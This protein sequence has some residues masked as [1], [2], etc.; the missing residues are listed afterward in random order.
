MLQYLPLGK[1]GQTEARAEKQFTSPESSQ[2]D[3]IWIQRK[4]HRSVNPSLKIQKGPKDLL[5]I[6]K[7]HED[8]QGSAP[9]AG[10][11]DLN[12][13]ENDLKPLR[14]PLESF[15]DASEGEVEPKN[16]S[17]DLDG[18]Q[19]EA[20]WAWL[21]PERMQQRLSWH[22]I[23]DYVQGE[24]PYSE[25]SS[26][27]KSIV[28]SLQDFDPWTK[29]MQKE[30][31][32][33]MYLKRYWFNVKSLLWYQKALY[34]PRD[35]ALLTEMMKRHHNNLYVRHFEYEKTFKIIQRKIF[36]PAMYSN[37]QQY[38][39]E[40]EVCQRTKVPKQRPYR[41]LMTLPQPTI[42]F[43]KISLNFIIKLPSSMLNE[44]VYDSILI[45]IN[46]CTQMLLYILTT[47]I[48]TASALI[49]LLKRGMFNCFG[50]PDRVV[51]NWGSLFMSH[52]YL[53]LCYWA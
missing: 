34:L 25:P 37:I 23:C 32:A 14:G 5:K 41:S 45:M 38:V 42:P 44:Q 8:L 22:I 2:I 31:E 7:S 47:E 28:H 35:Y 16:P 1:G 27:F 10:G 13:F 6:L 3:T 11:D 4:K 43:K 49:E 21:R 20:E 33:E 29:K 12:D 19:L 15:E 51:S 30:A 9:K 48:I 52:Y 36:W 18:D 40:C 24:N 50:Y 39:K 53:W 46:C 26:S 17:G